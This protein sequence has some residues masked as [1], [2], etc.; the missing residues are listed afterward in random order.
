MIRAIVVDDEWYILEELSD[1]IENTG[2]IKVVKRYENPVKALEEIGEASPEIAF[3]D[4]EMPEIDGLQLAEKLQEKNPQLMIAFITSWNQYAVQAFD[5]N[6]IDYIMKPI[7]L[8]RFNQMIERIRNE[9]G[10]KRSV[11]SNV[12][13]IECFNRLQA[14]VGGIP[15]KWERAKAEEL[16]A[17][18]L[19]NHR[20]Y[21]HKDAI[22]D[23]LW[24]DYDPA[25]ALSILQTS[26]CKIRNVFSSIK[27]IR[28]DYSGSKYCLVVTNAQCDYF[29]VEGALT[30][31]K[32]QDKATY[33]A[34]KDAL[35]LFQEGFLTHN[36]YLWSMEKDEDLRNRFIHSLNEMASQYVLEGDEKELVKTLKLLSALV[37][38]DEEINYRLLTILKR[39]GNDYDA[40]NHYQWLKK[41]LKEQYSMAPSVKIQ[42]I[43]SKRLI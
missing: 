1:L 30:A 33:H 36:G 12:L 22:I 29:Q 11:Q 21:I 40:I 39:L 9:V 6:A 4:I 27:N 17:Y 18:L 2:I 5:L 7:R 34:V 37:P 8:E 25:K 35:M 26:I 20:K 42:K 14:S 28:I 32:A 19:M 31:F 24:P 13:K 15:V 41:I 23:D 43:F 3:L 38:Y 10:A 16:F